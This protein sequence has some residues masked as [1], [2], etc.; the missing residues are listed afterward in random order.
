MTSLAVA[1]AADGK[2]EVSGTGGAFPQRSVGG[3]V[4]QIEG[5]GRSHSGNGELDF[6]NCDLHAVLGGAAGCYLIVSCNCLEVNLRERVLEVEVDG[7]ADG[8]LLE[9]EV[10][11]TVGR[12]VVGAGHIGPGRAVGDCPEKV[13]LLVKVVGD[14]VSDLRVAC[15]LVAGEGGDAFSGASGG[16]ARTYSDG[17][18]RSIGSGLAVGVAGLNLIGPVLD[19]AVG[20]GF[21]AYLGVVHE[22]GLGSSLIVVTGGLVCEHPETCGLE[23][24]G[25]HLTGGT[26]LG[27]GVA[28][29]SGEA[30]GL[31]NDGL[32]RLNLSACAK[33]EC[34][35]GSEGKNLLHNDLLF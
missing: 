26:R 22:V 32:A 29:V 34:C 10:R 5:S 19:G 2:C 14:G 17:H 16:N 7:G 15:S 1:V 8:R 12:S 9:V 25:G 23:I 30:N 24:V 21:G 28:C 11:E 3:R 27:E 4:V 13:N 33:H 6:F 35:N 18:V 20:P 31:V